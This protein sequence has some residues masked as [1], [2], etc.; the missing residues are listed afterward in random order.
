MEG[1]AAIYGSVWNKNIKYPAIDTDILHMVDNIHVDGSTDCKVCAAKGIVERKMEN[2]RRLH[3]GVVAS[4]DTELH[5]ASGRDIIAKQTKALAICNGLTGLSASE[6]RF[7]VIVGIAHYS[8]GHVNIARHWE[9][10]AAAGAAGV[11]HTLC[12]SM[13]PRR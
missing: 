9:Q 4:G 5:F 1:E 11:F 3:F 13:Q 12:T 10:S 7:L 2:V 6:V 8:D